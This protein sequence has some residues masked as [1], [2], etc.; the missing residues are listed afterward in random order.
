MLINLILFKFYEEKEYVIVSV[1]KR[2]GVLLKTSV[3]IIT[4]NH[5]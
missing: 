4:E 1:P 3:Q 2:A 5:L